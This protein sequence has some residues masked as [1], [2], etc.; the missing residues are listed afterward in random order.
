MMFPIVPHFLF[1]IK[2]AKG[3]NFFGEVPNVSKEF[4]MGKSK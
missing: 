2:G 4:V 1:I 3:K